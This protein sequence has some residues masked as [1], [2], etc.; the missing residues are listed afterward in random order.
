MKFKRNGRKDKRFFQKSV[1]QVHSKNVS[2]YKIP[3]GG[4]RL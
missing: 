4:V 1:N 3:R 2:G